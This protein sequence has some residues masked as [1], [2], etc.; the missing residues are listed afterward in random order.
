ME[1]NAIGHPEG[2]ARVRML[3]DYLARLSFNF[4]EPQPASDEEILSVHSPE[5]LR[6]IQTGDFYDPDCPVYPNLE[7]YV[8]L[9]AGGAILAQKRRGFSIMRPP[10]HHAG[11]N[12]LG[13]FCYLN[14]LAIAVK[15][16]GQRTLIAD[17]DGH[18][19]NGTEA[20]F[21][22]DP[23]VTYVSLHRMYNY[24]GTGHSSYANALNYPLP[25]RCGKERYIDAL[26]EALARAGTDYAQLAVSAGFDTYKE[27]PL[28]S[29]GLDVEAY[30][31][32]GYVL[33]DRKLPT[34][35]VLEGGYVPEI[36]GPAAQAL[37]TGL[38]E[39][40]AITAG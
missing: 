12:F 27:D 1:Y 15:L 18:H 38:E 26:E 28:A 20:I 30:Y 17:I 4:L 9:S 37:I 22:G 36:M 24:P 8:R 29:V 21:L 25:P 14:N 33:G 5:L 10:G 39:G 35:C 13:G 7:F 2:P 32:I 34:F 23:K 31:D 40:G 19:G 3:A 11:P 16:S 6:R